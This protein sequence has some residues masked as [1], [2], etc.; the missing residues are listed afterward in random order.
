M[1][2][3]GTP[4]LDP[5]DAGRV[6][7]E[8]LARRPGY[9]P[10]WLPASGQGGWGLL[11]ILARYAEVIIDR[12]NQAPD[13]NKLAFL[14][15]LGISL[16]PAQ[17]ARAP[18]VFEPL[19]NAGNGRIPAGTRLGAEVPGRSEPLTFETEDGIAMAAAR[20]V[21]V[22]TLWPA[23]DQYADHTLDN[24]GGRGFE[25]FA[26]RKPVPHEL[27]LAHDTLFA[28]AGQATVEIEIDL[29]TTGNTPLEIA[30]EYW[31]GETWRPF[32][33]FDSIDE[34]AGRDGTVGLTR[35]GVVTL[36]ADCGAAK[37]TKV[38]GTEAY[39]VRGRLDQALPP[40]ATRVLP[41]IDR[42]RLRSSVER[43][44]IWD[45][46]QR[47]T[48]GDPS[49]RGVVFNEDGTGLADL[50]LTISPP[51]A[52]LSIDSEGRYLFEDV[53]A[54]VAY[55][56]LAIQGAGLPLTYLEVPPPVSALQVDFELMSAKRPDIAFADGLKLDVSKSFFPLGQR[57]QAGSTF[58]FSIEDVFAKPSA[59]LT[60]HFNAGL[61]R[62]SRDGEDSLAGSEP[63]LV[64]EYWNGKRWAS[65]AIETNP[66]ATTAVVRFTDT[67]QITLRVPLDMQPTAVNGEERR[68]MRARLSSGQ[69]GY[70]STIKFGTNTF[71]LVDIVPPVI[72]DIRLGYSYHSP[73]EPPEHCLTNSDFN[74]EVHSRDVRW[75]GN[76]F[77]PFR[78][79]SDNTPAL[80]LGFD[81]PLPND[82]VSLYIDVA[83]TET[84]PPSL[85]WESWNGSGWQELRP[86]DE[87][88]DLSRPGMV[89][90]I[91][92]DVTVRPKATVRQAGAKEIVAASALEAAVFIA[93]QQLTIKKGEDAEF[94]TVERVVEDTILLQ[95]PLEKTYQG[96]TVQLAALPRFGVPC[97]WIRARLKFD[98]A[99][100]VNGVNGLHVNAAWARQV[101]TLNDQV[102]GS[103][104]GQPKETFFFTQIPVL[105]GERIEVRELHGARAH[106]EL[107]VLREALLQ[108][109]MNDDDVRAV[110]DPRSGRVREVWV[111]WE[112]RDHLNFSGPE[113]RH[114]VIERARGRLIFGD[115]VNGRV[116]PPGANNILARR[117][118]AGG[119]IDGNVAAGAIT[120][121]FSSAPMVQAV[122]NPRAADGGA[123]GE[124]LD[125]V[126]RRG[127]QTLRHRRRALSVQDY[128]ALA[129]EASPGV[130]VARALPATAPN[131]RPAPGWVTVII[132]PQSHESEPQPSLELRDAVHAHLLARAPATLAP[133]RLAVIGP[134]YLPIGV[135]AAV[136]PYVLGE[137]GAVEEAVRAAL[138]RFLHPLTGGP[139][140]RG[141]AF[142]RAVYLSDI[143]AL[144]EASVG[145][146]HVEDLNL[147]LNG[148]P[149]G[150]WV[151]VPPDRIVVAGTLRVE[152]KAPGT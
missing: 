88:A 143:A 46:T 117:Y 132:V 42:L 121:L 66:Y 29:S 51:H 18:V 74:F 99:P 71:T 124:N 47:E 130:A 65:L 146:D 120:Q 133:E 87:T 53:D 5:R 20:L 30:W 142:G 104:N 41:E 19:P 59:L 105:P 4:I 145:V 48:H 61:A 63:E 92:P 17:P 78:P 57:P 113:D 37:K 95:A 24:A 149:R 67:G 101:Q 3:E 147:L 96:G 52:E 58:Y 115:G 27:Y 150:E 54:G 109:G 40:D 45:I 102:L 128:E 73:W 108:R 1:R 135:S 6:L 98:G 49:I 93:G 123:D 44:V 79:V 136:V 85:L 100:C 151:A 25:L 28:F 23:Q 14:D 2:R 62:D 116:P 16:I 36:H 126:Y 9:L 21:E 94:C 10:G 139:E 89:S 131:G 15:M 103:G 33:P 90:F 75:P 72:S 34:S 86:A 26:N 91:A 56:V 70:Q 107:P 77:A 141:W 69:Y 148:T 55:Y 81:Q 43:P 106:V 31:N 13:K 140:G 122:S 119:G 127:P 22:K 84:T 114:Y 76:F 152:M 134:T 138:A 80:Y 12:L 64:W 137:S 110:T 68:W 60:I 111:R 82:L 118:Q 50:S 112:E 129:C 32:K 125:E 11:Q 35:S 97:D 83:E 144:L 39:W 7:A 8:L 38:H